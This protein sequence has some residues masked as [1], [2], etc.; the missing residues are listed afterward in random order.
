MQLTS[1]LIPL[2]AATTLAMPTQYH[3][4]CSACE[5]EG[6]GNAALGLG[7]EALNLVTG[8]AGGAVDTVANLGLGLLGG[9]GSSHGSVSST[10]TTTQT[11]Q[12]CQPCEA[13]HAAAK[14]MA[15]G[16]GMEAQLE[17][18]LYPQKI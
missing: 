5:I 4:R 10:Q 15:R 11:G 2:L 14:M 12:P 16:L 6:I 9:G 8:V 18:W 17:G 13:A 3:P 1:L 7:G